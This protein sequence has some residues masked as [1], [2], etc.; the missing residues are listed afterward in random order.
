MN[1]KSQNFTDFVKDLKLRGWGRFS[2][3]GDKDASKISAE[4]QRRKILAIPAGG[5][6]LW[7][8]SKRWSGSFTE[9]GAF[10]DAHERDASLTPEDFNIKRL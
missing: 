1:F 2:F 9:W 3:V 10:D 5:N 7:Y 8:V 4:L 6:D